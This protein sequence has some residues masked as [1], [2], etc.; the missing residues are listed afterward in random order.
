MTLW[1]KVVSHQLL[2]GAHIILFLNK[3]DLFAEK[4]RSGIKFA[5]WVTSFGDRPNTLEEVSGCSCLL[6]F[7]FRSCFNPCHLQDMSKKFGM[8]SVCNFQ[9]AL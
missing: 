6:C 8:G 3:T 7:F 4:L 2:K 9:S 1:K 5:D